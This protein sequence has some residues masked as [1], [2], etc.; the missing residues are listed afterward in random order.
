MR[1]SYPPERPVCGLHVY[2]RR[3]LVWLET[4]PEVFAYLPKT[5]LIITQAPQQ[6]GYYPPVTAI[7]KPG[8]YYVAS[9]NVTDSLQQWPSALYQQ[10]AMA[11]FGIRSLWH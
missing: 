2:V 1:R 3:K 8:F 6:Q 10:T 5:P 4:L 9:S 11:M 7:Q